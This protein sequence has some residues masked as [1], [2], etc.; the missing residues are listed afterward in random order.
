ML[1]SFIIWWEIMRGFPTFPTHPP[2]SHMH[3]PSPYLPSHSLPFP[4]LPPI[5]AT[6]HYPP[7][8]PLIPSGDFNAGIILFRNSAWSHHFLHQIWQ[9]RHD[10]TG[11][12]QDAMKKLLQNANE[13][14]GGNKHMI[15]VPQWKLNSYPEVS[16]RSRFL[17]FFLFVIS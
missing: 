5:F 15:K 13:F 6:P 1:L 8:S 10:E 2:D 12:E 4:S 16:S 11:S 17:S 7:L 14:E 3:I 9:T